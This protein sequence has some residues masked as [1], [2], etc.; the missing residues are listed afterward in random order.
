[1]QINGTT[2]L[3][4]IVGNPVGH[5]LSPAMHNAAFAHLG[6]NA[7]YVPI[8][9]EDIKATVDGLRQLGFCGASITVPFKEGV[10]RW[11]DE[12]DHT[13]IQIGAV[14]TLAFHRGSDQTI[15]CHG[16]NTDWVGSNRA[17]ADHLTLSGSSALILGAGGAAKAVAF[18]LVN[19]GV[20]VFI[21]NRTHHRA[22][23]L[24]NELGCNAVALEDIGRLQ[25]EIL[26]NTTSV[27]MA[28]HDQECPIREALLPGFR[29]VMDIVYAPLETRLLRAARACG[30]T[31]IDGLAMLH[32]QGA[33]QFKIWTG[34]EP[35][36]EVMRQALFSALQG[37]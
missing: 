32:Y 26:I 34:Q 25:C 6:I 8:Q 5:S 9:A 13:A 15:H 2:R 22:R 29:V 17:L 21:A 3:Y 27:G 19:A 1:M 7:A 35:P 14:N 12:L 11:V 24:A 37:G 30:C 31:V 23:Q 10:M 28:P 16:Y 18:G 4:A 33:A 36:A 20:E